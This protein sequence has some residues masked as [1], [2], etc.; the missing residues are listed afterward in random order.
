M[1]RARKR[2]AEIAK[3]TSDLKKPTSSERNNKKDRKVMN[4]QN[5]LSHE[6]VALRKRNQVSY[7][8]DYPNLPFEKYLKHINYLIHSAI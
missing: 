7:L 4:R 2:V 1:Q 8:Y 5:E 3:M 6:A